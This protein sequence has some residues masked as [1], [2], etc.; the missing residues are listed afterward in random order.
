[1][2]ANRSTEA[3]VLLDNALASDRSE[4][5]ASAINSLL[6][7]RML[8]ADNLSQF[9]TSAQRIPAAFSEN[10][11]GRE[12]PTDEKDAEEIAKG[13]KYFFDLDAANIFN[14]AMPVAIMKDAA[15]SK[16]LAP[17][18]RRDVAQ[19]AFLRAALLDD[20]ASAMAAAPVLQE[21]YP[22]VKE[23]VT[24]YERAATPDA[25]RFAAAFLALKNPGLRPFVST[26]VG[27]TTAVDDVDSYRDN[28]W[29]TEP[30][31]PIGEPYSEEQKPKPIVAPDFLKSSQA[32]AE[33]Q[34]AAIQ[35]LDT[36]PNF[37]CRTAID[38]ANKNPADPRAPEA[39][40][41][42]V[43]STRYGC[44]NEETGKWSK[45]AFDLLHRKYPNTVWAK[46]T[47][48]WFKG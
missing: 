27:R 9:L 38:W 33:K 10:S 5:N 4:M 24:A 39:L 43:R 45:A 25:R 34:F 19:A 48:Y 42:A 7:M 17:N 41:L 31:P 20:R 8:L 11:D 14:K 21:L 18:L 22:Q 1:M 28:Y 3:Q 29:C 23:F 47:K 2:E 30:P 26:G 37:L 46:N 13:S 32:V 40:H 6:S 16:L 35:A 12:M 44:T 15:L 36:A